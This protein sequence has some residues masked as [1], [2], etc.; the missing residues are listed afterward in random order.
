MLMAKQEPAQS[1][2][3]L[4]YDEK[5]DIWAVGCLVHELLTG[6]PYR[7]AACFLTGP[8]RVMCQYRPAQHA[9]HQQAPHDSGVAMHV[10]LTCEH[11]PQPGRRHVSL[12]Q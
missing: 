4:G 8:T 1:A 12:R 7:R 9:D 11:Q 3:D 10:L 5:V 6:D 2:A